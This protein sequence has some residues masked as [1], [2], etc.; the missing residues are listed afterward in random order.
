[1]YVC[2]CLRG[3]RSGKD[4]PM[5]KVRPESSAKVTFRGK[6]SRAPWA[7]HQKGSD[8]SRIEILGAEGSRADVSLRH[9]AWMQLPGLPV[10]PFLDTPNDFS[11]MLIFCDARP[12]RNICQEC[13]EGQRTKKESRTK[14]RER[15]ED[16]EQRTVGSSKNRFLKFFPRW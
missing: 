4:A 15:N 3:L 6:G 13:K 12:G 11:N 5:P 14:N 2:V 16:G 1:M 8:G 10:N 9:S 7:A